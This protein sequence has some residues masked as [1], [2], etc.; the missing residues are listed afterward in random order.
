MKK[1]G[2]P[3]IALTVVVC[4]LVLF[5]A[6]TFALNGNPFNRPARTLLAQL[7]DI[8]GLGP[9]SQV[10][11]AGAV[12]GDIARV[13]MLTPDERL[14]SAH[15]ENAVEIT[16]ALNNDVP[17]LNEG[18]T[19]SVSSDTLLSDKFLLLEGGDPKAPILANGAT[20]AAIPPSTFDAVLRELSGF[21]ARIQ[22]VFG[23][24]QNNLDGIW[25]KVD[26]LVTSLQGTVAKI[27]T[28]I[29]NGDGLLTNVNGLVRRGDGFVTNADQLVTSSR[30]LVD[31]NADAVNRMIRQLSTAAD[32]L[33]SL[34]RR[35]D[36][37][38]RQNEGH[39]NTSAADAQ[40]A[41]AELRDTAV[42]LHSFVN[43]LRIRPQ[44]LIWGPGRQLPAPTPVSSAE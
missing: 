14:A 42:S 6:L 23:G 24:S 27:D 15:P 37:L 26:R 11:Y 25:P 5:F 28:L 7:P 39:I 35:T 38:I 9:S 40:A 31:T 8:T 33:D 21:M 29:G 32:S 4:S 10:K 16:I 34:A 36:R 44:Q 3:A 1:L 13:R 30:T 19:A 41:L 22:A 20:I 43:S 12:A 17:P 2:D 18:L